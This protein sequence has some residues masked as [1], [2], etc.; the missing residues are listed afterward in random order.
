MK[1]KNCYTSTIR[2]NFENKATK[3]LSS[4]GKNKLR[5]ATQYLTGHCELNYYLHKYKPHKVSK[6]C[7]YCNMEEETMNL[8]DSV[9]CGSAGE[10]GTLNAI[11]ITQASLRETTIFL[12]KK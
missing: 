6:L 12:W 2:Q 1:A 11:S 7:P 8:S 3:S 10:D 9:R 5:A 4:L